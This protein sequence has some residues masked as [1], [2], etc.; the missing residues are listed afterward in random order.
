MLRQEVYN[1]TCISTLRLNKQGE[2]ARSGALQAVIGAATKT[3]LQ[4]RKIGAYPPHDTPTAVALSNF[5]LRFQPETFRP[6]L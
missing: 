4:W 2:E 6:K 3:K 1:R 5:C